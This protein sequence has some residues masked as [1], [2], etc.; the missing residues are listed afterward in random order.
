MYSLFY[1]FIFIYKL[2]EKFKNIIKEETL[3]LGKLSYITGF[4]FIIFVCIC[5]CVCNCL[6]GFIV[7]LPKPCDHFQSN[8]KH[9]TKISIVSL[10]FLKLEIF[11]L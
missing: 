11:K 1:S 3:Y 4:S 6:E 8:N 7:C 9:F 2:L 5:M 10:F